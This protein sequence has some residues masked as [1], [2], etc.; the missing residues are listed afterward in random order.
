MPSN[1][2]KLKRRFVSVRVRIALS[3]M[4]I[5][6]AAFF[7][8]AVTLTSIAGNHLLQ[9]RVRTERVETTRLASMFAQQFAA[10]DMD[11]LLPRIEAEGQRLSG[12]LMLIDNDGRV[13]ADSSSLQNGERLRV[14]EVTDILYGAESSYGLHKQEAYFVRSR[15][16][17]LDNFRSAEADSEWTG[18]FT[19]PIMWSGERA[20][21]ILVSVS[22]QDMADSLVAMQDQMMLVFFLV[23]V[24]GI[25]LSLFF[26]RIITNP[27]QRLAK[28]IE[29]MT[30]GDLSSRVKVSGAGEMAR[31]AEAF[32]Q[33]SEKLEHVDET[34]NQFVSNASHELKTPL[35]TMKILIES[36]IYEPSMDENTRQ[37]FLKDINREIDRLTAITSDLLTLVKADSG[38]LKLRRESFR[39]SDAVHDM[40]KR[41]GPLI[42]ERQQT[43]SMTLA[44]D[45]IIF[46][47]KGK[48]SQMAYNL[49]ENAVK[50]TPTGG[51]IQ[52]TLSRDGAKAA[53]AITD[54]GIGIP[55]SE[56]SK[57]F[58]RFYRVDR[59][60]ARATGGSGLGLAIVRQIVVMHGGEISVASEEGKGSTFT[61]KIP[62]E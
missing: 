11:Q 58:D 45:V 2:R 61:V 42:E 7:A 12:R 33:M 29:R 15:L 19:A 8:C 47:D 28:G 60:R 3:F 14:P 5:L 40:A 34:R 37:E 18:M 1:R 30:Y 62:L 53:L 4:V 50:Y 25:L 22:V 21:V 35:S 36:M 26:S 54:N 17:W 55:E 38:E 27:I 48:I 52:V 39:Y 41:L 31:L 56:R 23:G 59:A 10:G 24:F 13:Q 32:N 44:D 20:G 6:V 51:L 57:I 43:L 16:T 49:M 46:A 9:S